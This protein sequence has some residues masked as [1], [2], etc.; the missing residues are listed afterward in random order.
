MELED[1]VF[2]RGG[3]RFSLLHATRGRPLKAVRAREMFFRTAF[4]PISIEHTFG[5]DEDDAESLK[6]L[7]EYRHLVIEEP[8]GCV[9]AWNAL[10]SVSQGKVLVQVS[11]D[12]SPPMHWDEAIWQ[13]LEKETKYR[14]GPEAN[15]GEVPLVV[16]IS[17]G[18]RKDD[19]FCMA[20][21]TRARYEQQRDALGTKNAL[22]PSK[23]V[24]GEPYLFSPE[25]YS[26]FSDNEFTVRA[27]Q[28]GVVLDLRNEITFVHEHPVFGSAEWDDTYRRQNDPKHYQSGRETFTRRNP[29]KTREYNE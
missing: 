27:L 5:I 28:D 2:H 11:D 17:D 7:K 25:Y 10:A 13:A 14:G 29:Q 12:W 4:I 18:H 15:V 3:G 16:A 6:H 8:N 22:D 23:E 19:L 20:I 21:L 24:M 1:G 9:K 26:M